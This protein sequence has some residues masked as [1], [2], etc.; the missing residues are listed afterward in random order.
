MLNFYYKSESIIFILNFNKGIFILKNW[1]ICFTACVK[2]E[3]QTY[4]TNIM[5][6]H[7]YLQLFESNKV[8]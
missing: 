6:L 8:L 5:F 3:K 2:F 1:G 4:P 7:K